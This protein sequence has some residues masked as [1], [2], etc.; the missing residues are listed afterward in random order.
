M[1]CLLDDNK[2]R[3]NI[4]L[5]LTRDKTLVDGETDV[6][7]KCLKDGASG[8]DCISCLA[9]HHFLLSGTELSVGQFQPKRENDAFSS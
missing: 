4:G 6:V 8:C 1:L 2:H 3:F 9:G 7:S 5:T